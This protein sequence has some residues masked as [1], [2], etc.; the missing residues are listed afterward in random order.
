[1]IVLTLTVGAFNLCL[2]YAL[3]VRLGYGP[4][5]LLAGWEAS[6]GDLPT[7]P[8]ARYQ[9]AAIAGTGEGFVPEAAFATLEQILDEPDDAPYDEP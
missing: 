2:G 1:M 9:P 8:A 4:P 5:R 6:A 3:A 7:R